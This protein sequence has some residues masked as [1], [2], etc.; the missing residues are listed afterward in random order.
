MDNMKD[1]KETPHVY[2][3]T[4]AR[5]GLRNGR[6]EIGLRLILIYGRDQDL[7]LHRRG[8]ARLPAARRADSRP[9]G[10]L[11]PPLTTAAIPLR[12]R[13]SIFHFELESEAI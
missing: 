6:R 5:E 7:Q 9:A 3:K 1:H 4:A 12:R 8:Y 2:A 10:T 13:A 11:P